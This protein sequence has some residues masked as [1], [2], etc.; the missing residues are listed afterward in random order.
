[1]PPTRSSRPSTSKNK[2]PT[3]FTIPV[4]L[5]ALYIADLRKLCS[6]LHVSATGGRTGLVNRIERK[7]TELAPPALPE[8]T[9]QESLRTNNDDSSFSDTQLTQIQSMI[10]TSMT[11]AIE[12]AASS[13]AQAAVQA[14]RATPSTETAKDHRTRDPASKV[15]KQH[16]RNLT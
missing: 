14:M 4:N 8:N 15:K 1:M 12:Q 6:S 2:N 5:N 7:R 10:S 16:A 11:Q 3:T 9:Q 13:A